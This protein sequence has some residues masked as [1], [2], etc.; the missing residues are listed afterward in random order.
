MIRIADGGMPWVLAS[1]AGAFLF[2]GASFFTSGFV[3]IFLFIL[4]VFFF[5]ISCLLIVFF[6]DP[7]RSI[8]RGIVAVAD[9]KIREIITTTGC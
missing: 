3:S 2:L 9:G 4:S 1:F 5:L 6:R 7:E 8:G